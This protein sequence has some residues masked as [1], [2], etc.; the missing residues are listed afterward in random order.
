MDWN[1]IEKELKEMP[2]E[3]APMDKEAF[4]DDF[5][6]RAE[7]VNQDGQEPFAN[8]YNPG[9]VRWV[10]IISCIAIVLALA[11][12]FTS[13]NQPVENNFVENP[14]NKEVQPATVAK[15]EILELD[16]LASNDGCII[17]EE[18]DT[19]MIM[20]YAPEDE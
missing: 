16:I 20:I 1:E 6:A 2:P 12:H 11:F 17:I 7:L 3:Q 13:N 5:R 18:E 8:S 4:W 19:T 10:V 9:W 15:N 14:E